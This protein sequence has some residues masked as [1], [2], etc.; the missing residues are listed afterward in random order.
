MRKHERLLYLSASILGYFLISFFYIGLLGSLLQDE[1]MRSVSN[2]HAVVFLVILWFF[3]KYVHQKTNQIGWR[4]YFS[5]QLSDIKKFVI[6]GSLAMI[7]GLLAFGFVIS[8]EIKANF[9]LPIGKEIA[10]NMV[11]GLMTGFSEEL[12]F[13][14]LIFFS[15]FRILHKI[16]LSAVISSIFFAVVHL[17]GL[18]QSKLFVLSVNIFLGGLVLSYVY[19]ISGSIWTAI[20]FHALNNFLVFCLESPNQTSTLANSSF[21]LVHS[22]LLLIVAI[23]LIVYVRQ[24]K[25]QPESTIC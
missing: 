6:G 10:Q 18:E 5:F 11:K 16:F 7:L 2:I 12:F 9:P 23:L 24:K 25:Y 21:F 8:F 20:G 3:I 19:L 15:L 1:H 17:V 13:R 4:D 14:G 22:A